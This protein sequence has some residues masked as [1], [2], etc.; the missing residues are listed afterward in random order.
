MFL[1]CCCIIPPYK[2]L[3][4]FRRYGSPLSI[5]SVGTIEKILP[6]LWRRQHVELAYRAFN[7]QEID[8]KVV[9]CIRR[10]LVSRQ[11]GVLGIQQIQ[12]RD[13]TAGVRVGN[14]FQVSP[15]RRSSILGQ[16]DTGVGGTGGVKRRTNALLG[17]VGS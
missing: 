7:L 13:D 1:R 15:R 17:Y 2:S 5:E 12:D 16:T 10:V 14:E 3:W 11:G 4:P 6:L 9:D 8:E